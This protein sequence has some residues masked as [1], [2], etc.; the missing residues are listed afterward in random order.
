[1]NPKL[2]DNWVIEVPVENEMVEQYMIGERVSLLMYLRDNL[3]NDRITM[4]FKI[5]NN[6]CLRKVRT[7]KE[8]F[9]DMLKKNDALEMLRK[10][11]DLELA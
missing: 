9:I 11:L 5:S 3:Q 6:D 4:T 7:R 2:L 8:L 1:M 10:E